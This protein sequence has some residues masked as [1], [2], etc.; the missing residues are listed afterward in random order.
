MNDAHFRL[1]F[2]FVDISND[3]EVPEY[4]PV[5][6]PARYEYY[7]DA[8]HEGY[9][10]RIDPRRL[11]LPIGIIAEALAK[12]QTLALSDLQPTIS[13]SRRYVES[14]AEAIRSGI[15]HGI[16][17]RDFRNA[18]DSD[19][20]SS[21]GSKTNFVVLSIDLVGSTRLSQTIGAADYARIIQTYSSEIAQACAHFHGRPLKF[22]GDGAILYF[23]LG[24]FARRHDMAMDCALTLRDLV[25]FGINPA[26]EERGVAPLACRIGA[27][28]GEAF[29]MT[30]GDS[31]TTNHIDIVG[32]VVNIATKVEKATPTNGICAGESILINTHTIW[33][34]NMKRIPIP[35]DWSY[36]QRATADPY[37]VYLLDVSADGST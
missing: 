14:R 19:L 9:F 22:M 3:P 2:R 25:L 24:T 18:A 30:I 37:H 35:K 23:S 27:D 16:V 13:D 20:E 21:A 1:D 31:R 29:V 11:F 12:A 5:P 34:K 36:H 28:S 33:A 26:L 4:V 8:D 7:K 10:D 6:D 32:E 17:D 15:D